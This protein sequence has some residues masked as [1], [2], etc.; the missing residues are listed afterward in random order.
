MSNNHSNTIVLLEQ[1]INTLKST[2]KIDYDRHRED[3]SSL[4]LKYDNLYDKHDDHKDQ[5]RDDI[6]DL[7]EKH[8]EKIQQMRDDEAMYGDKLC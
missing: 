4:Q 1:K 3:H 6:S 2:I 5:C 8:A 7:K